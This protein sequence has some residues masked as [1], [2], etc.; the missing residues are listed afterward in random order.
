MPSK[1]RPNGRAR[2]SSYEFDLKT[3]ELSRN[4]IRFRLESQ[5][6]KVLEFLIE[7]NGDLVSRR[8]LITS[9]RPGEIE[10]NFDRRLDKAVAKLRASLSDDPA[11]PRYIETLK[12]RGYRFLDAVAFELPGSTEGGAIPAPP[13][14][15]VPSLSL[16]SESDGSQLNL[17]P[18]P[19]SRRGH[20]KVSGH[21]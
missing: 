20:F 18:S 13:S 11:K 21:S 4:G 5:P 1:V 9:L 6:A 17:P 10:G 16:V 7:A 8:D 2:F 12:G 14:N 3:G 15:E 19:S